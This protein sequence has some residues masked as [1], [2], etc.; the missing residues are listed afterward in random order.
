MAVGLVVVAILQVRT[1]A[2]G[3]IGAVREAAGTLRPLGEE[4]AEELA[5]ASTELEALGERERGSG[6]QPADA[7]TGDRRLAGHDFR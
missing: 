7:Y 4:L 1:A 3:L 5:V 2:T 6:A